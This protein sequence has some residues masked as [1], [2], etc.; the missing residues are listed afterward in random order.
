MV[1]GCGVV[2]LVVVV[3]YA[4]I[5]RLFSKCQKIF[6]FVESSMLNHDHSNVLNTCTLEI[7]FLKG[8]FEG[9]SFHR[10]EH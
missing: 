6:C 4:V 2:V 8:R 3:V 5:F 7:H 9:R 10:D 1:A